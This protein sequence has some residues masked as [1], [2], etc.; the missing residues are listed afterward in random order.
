MIELMT[1]IAIMIL[2]AGILLASLPGIQSKVNRNRVEQFMAELK[3]GLSTY[4]LDNGIYP[5]NVPSGSAQSERDTAGLE[6]SKVLYKELSGDRDLDGEVDM[7]VNEKV[8]VQ[9]LSYEENKNSKNP[10]STAIGGDFQVVDSYGDPIR[11]LA[12][13]PNIVEKDRLTFNPDYDLWSIAGSDPTDME[14]QAA[15]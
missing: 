13:P 3:G 12:Q 11:Y 10:R 15:I 8:Y 5:Q 1:V 9:R 6:G 2:L 4:Q 14:S 7:A